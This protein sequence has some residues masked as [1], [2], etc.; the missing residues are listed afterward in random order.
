MVYEPIIKAEEDVKPVVIALVVVPEIDDEDID[1]DEELEMD[2]EEPN[3]MEEYIDAIAPKT[4][5]SR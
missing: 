2:P 1:V 4:R 3:H 5:T